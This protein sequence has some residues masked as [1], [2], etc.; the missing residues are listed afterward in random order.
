LDGSLYQLKWMAAML[1][2]CSADRYAVNKERMLRLSEY[3]RDC[4]RELR[5]SPGSNYEDRARG[6]L[7]LFRTDAQMAAARR[8]L[9]GRD[10]V[11]FPY[12]L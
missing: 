3:S 4:L 11:C 7:Q 12:E 5:A 9:A 1:A 10:E 6:T 2:N 8:D